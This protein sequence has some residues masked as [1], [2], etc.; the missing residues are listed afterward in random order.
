[1]A[2]VITMLYQFK[3]YQ[4]TVSN[5]FIQR[6]SC[7]QSFLHLLADIDLVL[8]FVLGEAWAIFTPKPETFVR[9]K[10]L[11]TSLRVL[12]FGQPFGIKEHVVMALI[13]SSGNNG[14]SGVE[15]Y[16]VERLYYNHSVS[17]LTAVLA[18]FSISLCGFVLAGL[19]RPLIV[20]PAEMVYWSTLQQVVLFQKLHF[21]RKANSERL[22]KFGYALGLSSL[23]EIVPGYMAPWFGG[24][25]VPCLASINASE[26]TR[27]RVAIVSG[28]TSSNEGLGILSFGFDWQCR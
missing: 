9:A 6:T 18:T 8:A 23:W 27:E 19:F 26:D 11:Q 12:N 7:S 10:W 20:Y 5:V 25:S 2:S 14:L 21:D 28:G 3:P 15:L 24:I 16:A 17:A 4:V 22:R 1:M 13:A